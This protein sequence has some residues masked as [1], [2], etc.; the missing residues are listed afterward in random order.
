M[1][2]YN[3]LEYVIANLDFANRHHQSLVGSMVQ[4]SINNS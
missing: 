3:Q 2:V 1:S 4:Q